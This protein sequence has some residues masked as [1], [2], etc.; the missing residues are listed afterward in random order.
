MPRR[1]SISLADVAAWTNLCEA[2]WR[3]A[4]GKRQRPEVACFAA[5]LEHEL[6]RLRR[7]ILAAELP[8][9]AMVSFEIHDPK[10][11]LIHAPCFRQRVLHHALM[12]LMAPVIER[13]LVSDTFACIP[14]RG[15]L[16]AVRR[17]QRHARRNPW[18]AKIDVETYFGRIEHE[19]LLTDLARRFKDRGL[20][21]LCQ[22]V[23]A[24]YTTS[25]GRGLPIGALTSQHFANLY[26]GPLDRHLLE[27]ARVAGMVRYMDDTLWW[28]HGRAA[29]RQQL[30]EV[31]EFLAEQRGLTVKPNWQIN[32]SVHG[33][34]FCGFRVFPDT[35][36]LS[37]RRKRRYRHARRS[38][39]CAYNQGAV[40][41]AGLQRAYAG[42]LAITAHANAR[43]WRRGELEARP[44]P[45][46]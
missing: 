41:S 24:Q 40:T 39:E 37:L 28:G 11:R 19:R 13:S 32:R 26:L 22:R 4:R 45:E 35:L 31:V 18:Y 14:G 8:E 5:D 1:S 29:V 2:F 21:A 43:G 15:T 38:W 23:I 27:R 30:Q 33:A 16:A 3:A 42:V 46:A 36:R 10:R 7:Q 9:G 12:R 44:A 34:P 6:A 17:A 25:S 20:L